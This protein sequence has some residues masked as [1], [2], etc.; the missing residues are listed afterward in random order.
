MSFDGRH[1][2]VTGG[3]KGI[4]AAAV[5]VFV[6]EGANVSV[7]D[8]EKGD[9][10]NQV[11]YHEC[12][13]AKSD[14]VKKVIEEA[15]SMYGDI[16]VLVNNAGINRYATVTE[17]SEELWDETMDVN[18]KSAFLLSKAAIPSMQNLGKGVIVNVSSVQAFIS[19]SQ[20]A[21]YTTSKT[22]MLG[23]TRSIA[24]DYGPT[25]RCVAVC[26]GTIDTPMLRSAILESPDPQAVFEECED[27]HLVKKVGDAKEVGEFIAYLASEK[28]SFM[29]G[30]A[31]RIDGGL[32]ISIGG[33]KREK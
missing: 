4:G 28:A 14:Q 15:V 1:I 9:S 2:V 31:F 5:E 32:G 26:P 16:S 7:L 27:M 6:R 25:I 12:N 33:S 23:L 29:T 11:C 20:V 18:L 17:T 21:A 8:L 24:V 13:V 3:V 22:A 30:Q 10:T 19:Q